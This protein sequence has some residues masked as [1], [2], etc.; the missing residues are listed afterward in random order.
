MPIYVGTELIASGVFE[1]RHSEN[2]INP[3]NYSHLTHLLNIRGLDGCVVFYALIS[4]GKDS[5]LS[6]N[7]YSI[8]PGLDELKTRTWI[9]T[10][11]FRRIYEQ[12]Q[13]KNNLCAELGKVAERVPLYLCL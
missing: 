7:D 10:F 1:V 9:K 13:N 11:A 3:P 5:Y 4:P 2:I 12:D 8:L 6:N